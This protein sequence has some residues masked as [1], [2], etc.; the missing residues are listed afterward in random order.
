LPIVAPESVVLV[1]AISIGDVNAASEAFC[2]FTT[3]PVFPESVKLAG[4]VPVQM[5]WFAEAVPPT[6]VGST[7]TDKVVVEAHCPAV[8]VKV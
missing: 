3:D 8:G 5:V 2:H 1:T 6:D 4:E 7:V